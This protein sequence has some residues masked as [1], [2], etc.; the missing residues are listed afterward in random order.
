VLKFHFAT[1]L[2]PPM[3]VLNCL[4]IYGVEKH[5]FASLS[6]FTISHECFRIAIVLSNS[7]KHLESIYI[8]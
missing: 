6:A 2:I 3:G 4:R 5:V 7:L 1:M 8:S